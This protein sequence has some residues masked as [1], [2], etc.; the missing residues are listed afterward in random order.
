MPERVTLNSMLP[1]DIIEV[2][3]NTG[4]V[5]SLIIISVIVFAESGLLIGFFLPGDTLLFGAGILAAQNLLPLGWTLV[6]IVVSNIL[7]N[8]VGYSIGRRYGPRLFTK[9]DGILFRQEYVHKSEVFYQKH[10]GKTVMLARFVPIIRT[11]APIVA[12]IAKMDRKQFIF[13]NV[14]GAVIWGIGI[15]LAGYFIGSRIPGIE[16]YLEPVVIG[17]ILI[18]VAPTLLH[19]A[20]EPRVRH[21]IKNK[22]K[23]MVSFIFL[24][25]R[26]D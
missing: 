10:G 11:F 15:T 1:F 2:L 14:I 21:L 26:M 12:G 13:Y 17:V 3:Q 24:N 7:G 9:K 19:L 5:V 16:N 6:A 8:N 23:R 20:R 25:K 22:L 18:S 4:P